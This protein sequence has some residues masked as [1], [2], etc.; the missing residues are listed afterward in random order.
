[1]HSPFLSGHYAL[2]WWGAECMPQSQRETHLTVSGMLLPSFSHPPV[3]P[4]AVLERKQR[5]VELM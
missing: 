2:Q 3:K 4:V 1:M 5:L